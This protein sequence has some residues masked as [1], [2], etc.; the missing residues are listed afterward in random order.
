MINTFF[1][2]GGSHRLADHKFAH[3]TVPRCGGWSL[4]VNGTQVTEP[5]VERIP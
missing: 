2:F 5:F 4:I 1:S 3:A